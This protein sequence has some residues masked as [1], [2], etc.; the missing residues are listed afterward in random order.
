VGSFLPSW[1][2][3]PDPDPLTRLNPDPFRIRIR[4]RNPAPDK[5][6]AKT[7]VNFEINSKERHFLQ[8][9][10]LPEGGKVDGPAAAHHRL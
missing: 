2:R 7:Y 5:L 10:E 8:G 6:N 3:I 4:I 1:I 9:E